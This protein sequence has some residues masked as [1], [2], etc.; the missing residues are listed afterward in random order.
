VRLIITGDM[1]SDWDNLHLCE[2]VWVEIMEYA[3]RRA[4]DAI[5]VAGDMKRV[6]SPVDVRV[7]NWWSGAISRAVK[8]YG[9]RVII[10]LGN[11]DRV[12]QYTDAV[13]WFPVMRRAGAECVD[14]GPKV[15]EVGDGQLAMLP[16]CS[17]KKLLRQWAKDLHQWVSR[18][19][20]LIFHEDVKGC[21]YNQLAKTS[22]VGIEPE[23]LYPHSYRYCVG[24]HIH[25]RQKIGGNIYYAGNP[26]CQDWGEANQRKGYTVVTE[27]GIK[28]L[29]SSVPGWYDP[30]WPGFHEPG[31]WA[32]ARVRV[33]VTCRSGLGYL[34]R[35]AQA[36][37][38]AEG[39]YKGAEIY[40]CADFQ[41]AEETERLG[42]GIHDPDK[43]KIREYVMQTCPENID[44][45]K[46]TSYITRK[47]E[48]VSGR[49][50]RTGLGAEFLWAKG[51]N[52]L[53]YKE[54]GLRF[55][56]PG[57]FTIQAKNYDVGGRSNGG[58]KTS[59]MQTVSVPLFGTTFKGQ[60]HDHWARRNSVEKAFCILAL[61]DSQNRIIKVRRQRRPPRLELHVD[62]KD[63][64]A[65]MQ[66]Q[67]RDGTQ[68]LIEQ[69]T[70]FTWQT[71]ANAVYIDQTVARAFLAGSKSSR[72]AVLSRFQNLERFEKALGLVRK[73]RTA[74]KEL[75]EGQERDCAVLLER[76]AGY[77]RSLSVLVVESKVRVQEARS[78]VLGAEVAKK[79]AE[80]RLEPRINVLKARVD[81][82]EAAYNE[83]LAQ[84][85]KYAARLA[86]LGER[87]L[88]EK[89]AIDDM[90]KAA[91]YEECP[92]C[93][94][95][96]NARELKQQ[97]A[98][99][100]EHAQV[101]IDQLTAVQ[102]S[103]LK[104]SHNVTLAEGD[105]DEAVTKLSRVEKSLA[106][107]VMEYQHA[108]KQYREVKRQEHD[109]EARSGIKAK[110]KQAKEKLQELKTEITQSHWQDAMLAYCE[111]ALSRDGIPAFLNALLCGP[112]NVAAEYYAELFCDKAVQVRFGMEDGEFVPQIINATGGEEIDDQSDGEKALAGLI[113][114]FALREIAPKCNILILDEPGHGLDPVAARKFAVGLKTLKEKFKTIFV[115][116]HN[117]HMLQEW[118]DEQ[119]ILVTKKNG[120]SQV[121]A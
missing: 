24:G 57:I 22:E 117:L 96:V 44:G 119:T 72:T 28:F 93:H 82:M 13:N 113:A 51:R 48:K 31:D 1:Q 18:D 56:Q 29:P 27:T 75:V 116:T 8:K 77:E 98:T 9:L 83:A 20:V 105:H 95:R 43:D 54:V 121:E 78:A 107:V 92:V 85:R 100:K 55:D 15:I 35:I 106:D 25:L 112:L 19:A 3:Q 41:K 67:Q 11:H 86:T 37:S 76:I 58:G 87:R 47:V 6:Y 63:Q 40:V 59:L 70:G 120:I 12:G 118:G 89:K 46:A 38:R 64:S 2:Q 26:F 73:D 30:T 32:G 111:Q 84:E 23:E 101:T 115:A 17:N 36:R 62:G 81:E 52:F 14:K 33:R 99:L 66:P 21:K 103:H 60:K 88:L 80:N 5:V 108:E 74:L 68:G 97:A 91:G 4:M 53:G 79:A 42:I 10:D 7:T 49:W 50:V 109:S 110:L 90:L 102:K 71:L 45:S 39:K 69:V 16:F 34:Q 104:A 114:S 94:Q 61:R 65:G